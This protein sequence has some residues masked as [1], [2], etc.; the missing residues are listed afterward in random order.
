MQFTPDWDPITV[1]A[2]P[3]PGVQM[4]QPHLLCTLHNMF[5]SIQIW[6]D[7]SFSAVLGPITSNM[8]VTD[9]E[10]PSSEPQD[11]WQLIK[12]SDKQGRTDVLTS[13]SGQV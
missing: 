3:P 9:S 12:M 2:R 11:K 5:L 13:K 8:S 6:R 7:A 10:R 1:Q 4:C